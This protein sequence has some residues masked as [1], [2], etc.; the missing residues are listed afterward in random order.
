LD[1]KFNI[2]HL[3]W[4]DVLKR[5]KGL[6][7]WILRMIYRPRLKRLLRLIERDYDKGVVTDLEYSIYN[8]LIKEVI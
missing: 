8:K 6:I 7:G 5:Y 1:T 3:V 4:I 2:K